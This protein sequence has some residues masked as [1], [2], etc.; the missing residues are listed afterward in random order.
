M[1]SILVEATVLM[2]LLFPLSRGRHASNASAVSSESGFRETR[3]PEPNIDQCSARAAAA[4]SYLYS[5]RG[6]EGTAVLAAVEEEDGAEGEDEDEGEA[7]AEEFDGESTTNSSTSRNASHS[8]SAR[9]DATQA[10]YAVICGILE[11]W[12]ATWASVSGVTWTFVPFLVAG[13]SIAAAAAAETGG[14]EPWSN[15]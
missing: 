6:S 13:G 9:W 1:S 8:C 7:E 3:P 2:C 14:D 4:P 15:R 5:S 11:G 12:A 10:S